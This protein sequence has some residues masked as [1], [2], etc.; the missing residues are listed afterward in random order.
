MP[1]AQAFQSLIRLLLRKNEAELGDWRDNSRE[2]LDPNGQ[3][4]VDLVPELKLAPKG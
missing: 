3:M 1:L 4:M 2:A